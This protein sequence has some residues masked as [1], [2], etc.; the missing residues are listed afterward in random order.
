MRA[1]PRC[2]DSSVKLRAVLRAKLLSAVPLLSAIPSAQVR[3]AMRAQPTCA[4]SGVK[5]RAALRAKLLLS[6]V[7][8][9]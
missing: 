6:A 4:D 5:L 8:L 9:C 7:A 3:A 1:H 2:V